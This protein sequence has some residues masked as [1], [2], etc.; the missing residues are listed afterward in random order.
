MKLL[1]CISAA[2]CAS[3]ALVSHAQNAS[4]APALPNPLDPAA[5]TA[6]PAYQSAFQHYIV[7]PETKT[8]TE[9]AW[10][11]ANDEVAR[12]KGHAG[13]IRDASDK[14]PAADMPA[15]HHLHQPAKE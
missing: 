3:F 2:A 11:A 14:T 9:A 15:G 8:S 6:A 13:H 1:P 4:A 10:R 7:M 5:A 12:L